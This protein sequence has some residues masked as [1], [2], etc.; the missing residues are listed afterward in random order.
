[1]ST[2][3]NHLTAIAN[4][5]RTKKGTTGKIV[6]SNFASEILSIPTGGNNTVYPIVRLCS[7]YY[8]YSFTNAPVQNTNYYLA[9]IVPSNLNLL[10]Y[11]AVV[12]SG[13]TISFGAKTTISSSQF[14]NWPYGSEY[15]SNVR[16]IKVNNLAPEDGITRQN[17]VK[18][19]MQFSGDLE[20]NRFITIETYMPDPSG[21]GGE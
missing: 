12:T 18:G 5:I 14:D 6:A 11:S 3:Q 19:T 7:E 10:S 13:N 17:A 2:Q 20:V 15:S 16:L 8:T 1:M 4:A 21:P 9:I